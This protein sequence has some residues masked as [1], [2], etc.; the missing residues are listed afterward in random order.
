LNG[1]STSGV[2]PALWDGLAGER[3]IKHLVEH[4]L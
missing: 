4:A 2:V 3:I 1:L